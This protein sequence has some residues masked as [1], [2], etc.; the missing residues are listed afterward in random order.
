MVLSNDRHVMKA[1]SILD[2]VFEWPAGPCVL[3]KDDTAESFKSRCDVNPL[4]WLGLSE[5]TN[6]MFFF[7]AAVLDR[8]QG[9]RWG[10][11]SV[12]YKR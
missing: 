11:G 4:A 10:R 9:D 5:R 8:K 1:M 7:S 12:G 6:G 3:V 2:A